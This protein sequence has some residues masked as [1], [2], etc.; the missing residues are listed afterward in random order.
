M[1]LFLPHRTLLSFAIASFA[2]HLLLLTGLK[3]AAD[4]AA[5][6]YLGLPWVNVQLEDLSGHT[7]SLSS[8]TVTTAHTLPDRAKDALQ[9]ADIQTS[10]SGMLP[11]LDRT[12]NAT[13]HRLP[14]AE[15]ESRAVI[16]NQLLGLLQTRLSRY[17]VYPPLARSRGW[18]GTV[19]LGLRME[20]DGHLEKIRIE[21]GSGYAVLDDSALNSLKRLGN[22]VEARVWLE[23]HSLDMQIPVIFKLIEN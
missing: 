3:K 5:T 1:P 21:R 23:G 6:P 2:L 12:D 17:L 22:L 13:D 15:G 7:P 8:K 18:E 20:S 11:F 9:A 10:V 19:L 4:I 14:M 16:R